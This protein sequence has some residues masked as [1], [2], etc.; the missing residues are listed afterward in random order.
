MAGMDPHPQ[1]TRFVTSMSVKVCSPD[2]AAVE[3]FFGRPRQ[4]FFHKRGFT[5]ISLDGLIGMLDEYMV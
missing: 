4:E 1:G 2:S 5:G 3:G